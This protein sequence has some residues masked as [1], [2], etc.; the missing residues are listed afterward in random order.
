[1]ILMDWGTELTFRALPFA[2]AA[3]S[4]KSILKK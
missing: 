1:M 2:G 3:E 4:G